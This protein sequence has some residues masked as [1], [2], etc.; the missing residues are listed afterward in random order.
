VQPLDSVVSDLVGE[1][2]T[3]FAMVQLVIDLLADVIGD[4]LLNGPKRRILA[5]R[6]SSAS[7]P[8]SGSWSFPRSTDAPLLAA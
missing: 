5:S 6:C 7:S 8:S 4:G 3:R 2:L 1:T